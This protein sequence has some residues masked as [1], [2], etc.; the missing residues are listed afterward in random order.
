MQWGT[1]YA[2]AQGLLSWLNGR[3]PALKL[4]KSCGFETVQ[5]TKF[6]FDDLEVAPV[7]SML[8]KPVSQRKVE[9]WYQEM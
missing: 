3:P 9:N 5:V 4:Y 8:R 7:T 1:D 2:D 6:E